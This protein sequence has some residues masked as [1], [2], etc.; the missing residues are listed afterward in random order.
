MGH[1]ELDIERGAG[2]CYSKGAV[3]GCF[4]DQESLGRDKGF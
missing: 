4:D 3:G 2:E 1:Y